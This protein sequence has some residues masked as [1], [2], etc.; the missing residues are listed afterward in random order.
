MPLYVHTEFTPN[1]VHPVQCIKDGWNVIKDQYWLFVGITL[2]ALLIGQLA[3]MGILMAPMMCGVFVALFERMRGQQTEFGTVF[4]GFDYLGQ[5]LIALLL[6]LVPVIVILIPL[7][8]ISFMGVLVLIPKGDEAGGAGLTALVVFVMIASLISVVIL[9][10][11]SVLFTFAYPL[12]VDRK[13]SGVDAVK[14]SM[15]AGMANF[16]GLIGMFLLSAALGLAGVLFCYV[17]AFLVMPISFAATA[18]A[19]KQVFGFAP[20]DAFS[21]P[22]PPPTSFMPTNPT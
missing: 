15:K 16:W 18:C 9:L 17:G 10:A 13:M 2:V 21:P 3:P 20:A 4:K 11:V 19:Y 5:S 22:P 12:I 7:I 8:A 1:A 14:L 6:H